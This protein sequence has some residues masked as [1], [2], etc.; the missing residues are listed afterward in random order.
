MHEKT[1]R[2]SNHTPLGYILT[3]YLGLKLIKITKS[4]CYLRAF[5]SD[6]GGR[7]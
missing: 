5:L 3:S 1:F 4:Y 7:L 6:P 2:L